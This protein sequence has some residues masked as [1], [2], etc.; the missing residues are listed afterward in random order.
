MRG[1]RIVGMGHCVPDRVVTNDDLAKFID[2]SNEWIV[3]RTGIEE[4]RWVEG[5]VGAADLAFDA[6][7]SP[8]SDG[9]NRSARQRRCQEA[10]EKAFGMVE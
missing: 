5:N 9:P 3:Q 7:K 6:T 1:S 4:R 8:V 10:K 2:T